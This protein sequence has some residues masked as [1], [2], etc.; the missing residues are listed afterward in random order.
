MDQDLL[1]Q[2]YLTENI[3]IPD[4]E[5]E[6]VL[7]AVVCRVIENRD[8]ICLRNIR[9]KDKLGN[10]VKNVPNVVIARSLFRYAIEI[11]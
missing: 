7:S 11:K 5:N 4:Y 2:V 10:P 9:I 3:T 6:Y 8:T 1:Y